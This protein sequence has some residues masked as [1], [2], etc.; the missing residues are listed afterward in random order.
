VSS[1]KRMHTKSQVVVIDCMILFSLYSKHVVVLLHN[2]QPFNSNV[3]KVLLGS[4]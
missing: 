2:I 1:T 3:L 4:V